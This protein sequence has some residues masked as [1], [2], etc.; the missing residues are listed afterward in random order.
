MLKLFALLAISDTGY[1]SKKFKVF[2]INLNMEIGAGVK[3]EELVRHIKNHIQ[4]NFDKSIILKTLVD[5]NP[6]N[7]IIYLNEYL[8]AKEKKESLL[9]TAKKIEIEH[10]M[11]AS[12]KNIV[13]IREDAGMGEEEFKQYANKIGNKILLEQPINGS[14]SNDW[15]RVKKQ[16]SVKEK[17]G[18][19]DSDFPIAKSLVNYKKDYWKK[20]DID[21][22]TQK[23]ALRIA[24]YIFE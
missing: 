23:A 18:Y 20:E 12:G 10:I 8:F 9:F 19:K 13:A 11:P 5:S 3:T 24:N 15:F 14:I 1:S 7:G 4:K 6:T 22:A 21:T 17:R 16:N 2:L